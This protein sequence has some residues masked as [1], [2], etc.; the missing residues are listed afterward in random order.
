MKFR[1]GRGGGFLRIHDGQAE[2]EGAPFEVENDHQS[3]GE[4]REPEG[5]LCDPIRVL[6]WAV[7]FRTLHRKK[8]E[9][10]FTL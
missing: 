9:Y 7:P 5:I 10:H 8:P 4:G 3:W 2:L 6:G 1:G